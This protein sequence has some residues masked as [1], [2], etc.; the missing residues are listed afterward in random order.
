MNRRSQQ[1]LTLVELMVAL[2]IGSLVLLFL[3]EIFAQASQNS[4][5]QRNIAWLQEDGRIA[6]EV[7]TRELR[8][9][10]FRPAGTLEDAVTGCPAVA[11]WA[12]PATCSVFGADNLANGSTV[13]DG[14]GV[15][16]LND[17][18]MDDCNGGLTGAPNAPVLIYARFYLNG[19]TLTLNCSGATQP[20][21]NNIER[22]EVLYGVAGP[23]EAANPL[24]SIPNVQYQK[25]AAVTDWTRVISAR[26]SLLVRSRDSNLVS[27][28][29]TY[30]FD[31]GGDGNPQSTSSNDGYL[32]Q[33]FSSV[34]LLRNRV[35]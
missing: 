16:Y 2:T 28:A 18:S 10:G 30:W 9:A 20:L 11:N 5:L 12:A 22:L 8:L 7:I 17:G 13:T 32:R 4:R 1:G 35:P 6:L 31:T 34:V 19:S 3:V 15:A 29:Q 21:L 27:D 23:L 25:A 26:V 24:P 14:I 33:A